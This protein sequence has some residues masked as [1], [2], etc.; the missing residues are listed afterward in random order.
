[1]QRQRVALHDFRCRRDARFGALVAR[2][3]AVEMLGLVPWSRG[4]DAVDIYPFHQ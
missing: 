1:M 2:D 4:D 3:D